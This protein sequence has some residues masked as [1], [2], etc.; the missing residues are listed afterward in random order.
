MGWEEWAESGLGCRAHCGAGP[1]D[2]APSTAHTS[3]SQILAASC[4]PTHHSPATRGLL[5]G[6]PVLMCPSPEHS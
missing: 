6:E 2:L 3:T 5:L 1:C 4:P